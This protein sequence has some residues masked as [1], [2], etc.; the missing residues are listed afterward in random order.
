LGEEVPYK[1]YISQTM[2][3]TKPK[4]EL[5]RIY[6]FFHFFPGSKREIVNKVGK[7]THPTFYK[8]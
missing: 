6:P 5:L 7:G 1:N 8:L 3:I 4:E 2:D